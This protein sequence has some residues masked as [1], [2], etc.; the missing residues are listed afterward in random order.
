MSNDFFSDACRL[1][2]CSTL[3]Q[4]LACRET[5][6]LTIDISYFLIS[7]RH[8]SQHLRRRFHKSCTTACSIPARVN[9]QNDCNFTNRMLNNILTDIGYFVTFKCFLFNGVSPIV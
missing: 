3:T 7:C 5:A 9:N 2:Y 6:L 8:Q 4:L 1:Q